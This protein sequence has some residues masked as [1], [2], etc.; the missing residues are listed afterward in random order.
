MNQSAHSQ[1]KTVLE[2]DLAAY[3]DVA[4]MLEENLNVEAVKVFQDQIQ[5]FVDYGLTV[6]GLHRDD[7]VVATAGDNAILM[8][9]DAQ[10]MHKFAQAVQTQTLAHNVARSVE[11]AKR[12]FRMGAATGIVL[13]IPDEHRVVGS[14]ISR[15][16]RL[17]A[18]AEIGQLVV[19]L[20]TFDA[21]PDD[22][23]NAYGSVDIIPGKR[24]ERFEGRRCTLIDIPKTGYNSIDPVIYSRDKLR[25]ETTSRADVDNPPPLRH[26]CQS[27]C[28]PLP[29]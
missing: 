15:A 29:I 25:N 19:D 2:M 24:S 3:S 12:W 17:E 14:T 13:A 9:D 22:L 20:P 18:A 23:K 4:R 5:E 26:A 28:C 21:L 7:V 10:T 1:I 6:I 11:S 16:V 27:S 8:F